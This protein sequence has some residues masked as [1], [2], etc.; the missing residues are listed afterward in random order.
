MQR[1]LKLVAL[2]LVTLALAGTQPAFGNCQLARLV[3]SCFGPCAYITSPGQSTQASS[4]GDF[5]ALG[6]GDPA[7]GLGADSGTLAESDPWLREYAGYLYVAAQ[8]GSAGIDG[9]IDDPSVPVPTR[10]VVA[11]TDADAPSASSNGYF[12]VLCKE[13]DRFANYMLLDLGPTTLI[14]IPRP[15]IVAASRG[16]A[17][18]TTLMI[19]SPAAALA[20]GVLADP[21]CAGLIRGY[22]VFH[23]PRSFGTPPPSDRSRDAGWIQIAGEQPLNATT[24]LTLPCGL[25]QY[26][27][28]ALG[29]VFESGFETAHVSRNSPAIAC[30]PTLAERPGEF[31]LIRKRP[32]FR[33]RE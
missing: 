33:E 13:R 9:C 6:A 10:T 20:G 32:P 1:T 29:L 17:G 12:G 11:I 7:I 24:T 5:W 21:S 3:V 2:V 23:Q 16:P 18:Q 31:R 25:T 26:D 22:K 15:T 19:A 30:D 8:W 4:R 27:Y 14:P 28:L